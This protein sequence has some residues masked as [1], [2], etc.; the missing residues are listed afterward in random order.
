[1][2][3]RIELLAP[4][5]DIDSIKAAIAAGADAVYCGLDRFNA[6]NRATNISF[7]DLNGILRLA[8]QHNCQV[9]LTLNIIIV[10]SEIPAL[11]N[12]LNKLVN[13]SI[14]GVIIQDLGL[15]YIISNYFKRLKIHA[16]TQLTT[17]NE[18]QVKFLSKLHATRINLSREL[19]L[20][21]IKALTAV[22]HKQNMQTEVFVHGSNCIS[23]SGI[24]YMSSMHGGNS[25]NRG[26]CSQPCRDKYKT[27]L[28]GKDFPLNLK[29]NSAFS[30]L[31]ELSDAGVDSIKIEGR[32]KKFHYVYTVVDAWRRQL[33]NFYNQ[34]KV[35]N[36]TSE[37]RKVFN[38]DFS[39]AFLSGNISSDMFIDNPRDNSAIHLSELD[40]CSSDEKLEKAKGDVYDE[41][42]E[43][44]T[45]VEEKIKELNIAKAPLILSI[46]GKSGNR[47]KVSVITPDST[48]EVFSDINLSDVGKEAIN[49]GMLLKRLKA[50]NDTE[51]FIRKLDL[52][53][54]QSNVYLPFKQLTSLKRKLLFF[55]NGSREFVDPIDVPAVQ[56]H[57]GVKDKPTLAIL[58]SSKNDLH[59]CDDTSATIYFQLPGSF[60][61]EFV[62]FLEIFE[63]NKKL[64]PWFPA[65]LIGEDNTV[66]V[67]LLRKLKP[68]IIV[69][70]NTGIAF[71]AYK[72]GIR[73]IAGP[74]LNIVNSYSLICLK[75]NLNCS[76]AFISNEISKSQIK[77]IRCPEDFNL[78]YSIYHPIILMTSR[79]CLFHQVTG[80]AKDRIDSSCI[81]HCEK[82]ASITNLKDETFIVEKSKRN[83]HRIYNNI[84]YLNT[85]AITDFP[86]LFS[87]FLIDL[88]D[89]KTDTIIN[90]DKPG[91]IRI[92][93][94]LLNGHPDPETDLRS[95]IY[96]TTNS[97]YKKGI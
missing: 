5:G 54:L 38:R 78:F 25:G 77:G 11:F 37:L 36:D 83:Y 57:S 48:F 47:L 58:I 82:S 45:S 68:A 42:T 33:L 69:T 52:E 16:S 22:A 24:C 26:R 28:A 39:N 90:E 79:Q 91:V 46:S 74:S 14:D 56:K 20:N 72:S 7:D 85:D 51:Y 30:D 64:I 84:N 65:V 17:H 89:I 4:G 66:A 41:R 86:D 63:Q 73:W 19:N 53:N 49:N 97:Q 35:S 93:N 59:L 76:G 21:E 27:T 15:F 34:N 18:G 94:D 3:Q 40:G 55:L 43:I 88:R 6:R 87:G 67:E 32:I 12:L 31:K 61:N 60:K 71:E 75:E 96:P 80:C 50:L 62:E 1:M 8:H 44:I 95:N 10:D 92:F 2:N 70:D 29:D 9:F 81:P 13:T 23:F